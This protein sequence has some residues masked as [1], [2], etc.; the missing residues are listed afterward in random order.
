MN[1]HIFLYFISRGVPAIVGFIALSLFSYKLTPNEYGEYT[2]VI[3]M[4][5]FINSVAF[6]W[7]RLGVLRFYSSKQYDQVKFQSTIINLYLIVVFVVLFVSIFI[8]FVVGMKSALLVMLITCFQAWFELNLDVSRAKL[9]PKVYGIIMLV[10]TLIFVM[11]AYIFI[12]LD[13]G[14]SA[15]FIG[16]IVSYLIST[17]LYYKK[18]WS[19][20]FRLYYVE[21]DILKQL[22]SYGL[23]LTI[24]LGLEYFVSFSDRYIISYFKGEAL[25]GSYAISYDFV[26]QIVWIPFTVINSATYPILVKLQNEGKEKD[27]KIKLEETL[28]VLLLINIPIMIILM[29]FIPVISQYFIGPQFREHTILIAPVITVAT[30]ILGMNYYYFYLSFQLMKKTNIQLI[31]A[32]SVTVINLGLNIIFIPIWGILGAAYA[33]LIAY[34]LGTILSIVCTKN[35]FSLPLPLGIFIK[36]LF[37]TIGM[38]ITYWGLGHTENIW[39]NIGELLLG[40]IVYVILVIGLFP[41]IRKAV[42]INKWLSKR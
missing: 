35:M 28:K 4:A 42:K 34:T 27:L 20:H 14:S 3:T 10:K 25:A 22:L 9:M 8:Y 33:T 37:V 41:E 19:N 29:F 16:I 32:I 31:V 6:Q 13:Y 1:K 17:I 12:I 40:C 24:L 7:I 11:I 26:K 2:L 39:L 36:I 23:P 30:F 5:G 38:C 21:K 18:L 15:L